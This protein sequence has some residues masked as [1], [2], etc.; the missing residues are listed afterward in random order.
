MPSWWKF[1]Q[2]AWERTLSSR[3]VLEVRP[4]LN[5]A[6]KR[7]VR[8]FRVSAPAQRLVG[9]F[10]AEMAEPDKSFGGIQIMRPRH[11]MGQRFSIGERFQGVYDL[12]A[13]LR[14]LRRPVA[15]KKS[16]TG[17]RRDSCSG[18]PAL[19]RHLSNA[20]LSD[21][22]EITEI[23]LES[24]PSRM[25]YVYLNGSAMA[26]ASTFVVS[27]ETD[28]TSLVTQIWEYQEQREGL[29]KAFGTYVLRLHLGV[30]HAQVQHAAG[31]AGGEILSTDIPA[32]YFTV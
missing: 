9:A 32:E 29:V 28:A 5:I 4:A 18:L 13:F 20:F 25:R 16:I 11:R 30:V 26:G 27:E 12:S 10:A 1:D 22:G 2:E 15:Q 31:R 17:C 8:E 23:Q 19:K 3:R 6:V 21:Y 24:L 14:Q 7:D